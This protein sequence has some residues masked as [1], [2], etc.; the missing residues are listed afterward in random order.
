M[1][2]T[3]S[4]VINASGLRLSIV[5]IFARLIVFSRNLTLY[6]RFAQASDDLSKYEPNRFALAEYLIYCDIW[7]IEIKA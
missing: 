5:S 7:E 2:L 6:N 4:S 1:T 3:C